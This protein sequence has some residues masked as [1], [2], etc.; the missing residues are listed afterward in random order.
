MIKS[1]FSYLKLTAVVAVLAM[2]L[3][4]SV[5]RSTAK[6]QPSPVANAAPDADL[7]NEERVLAKYFDDLF[8]YDKQA[9]ELSKKA[10]FVRADLDTLQRKSDDLKGRL[11]PLQNSIREIVRKLKAAN[12]WEDLDITTA[13]KITDASHKS[14][15]QQTSFK[16]VLVEAS[17]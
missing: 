10:S 9:A 3:V 17:N 15:F 16:Q 14:F 4:P 2:T 8:A 13:A 6:N 1:R 7:A 5:R 12:E 11:S